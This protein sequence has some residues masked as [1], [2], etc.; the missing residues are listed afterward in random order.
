M[1]SPS[2]RTYRQRQQQRR[3]LQQA[4]GRTTKQHTSTQ[5]WLGL[6]ALCVGMMVLIYFKAIYF[7]GVPAAALAM[8]IFCN[9]LFL[10]SALASPRDPSKIFISCASLDI[11]NLMAIGTPIEEPRHIRQQ[12]LAQEAADREAVRIVEENRPPT[13]AEVYGRGYRTV[14]DAMGDW[15]IHSRFFP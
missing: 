10:M 5:T 6:G 4:G 7:D 12:R 2:R 15:P 14:H 13:E 1:S 9:V 8:P 3:K 11:I